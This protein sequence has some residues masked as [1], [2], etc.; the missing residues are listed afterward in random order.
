MAQLKVTFRKDDNR[1]LGFQTSV[2]GVEGEQCLLLTAQ[3]AR[4]NTSALIE[5]TE[6]MYAEQIEESAAPLLA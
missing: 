6:A 3:I 1:L 4:L 5:P 2:N